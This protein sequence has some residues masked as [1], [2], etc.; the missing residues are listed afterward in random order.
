IL[1]KYAA[2]ATTPLGSSSASALLPEPPPKQ[3]LM[4]RLFNILGHFSMLLFFVSLIVLPM[5]FIQRAKG[6]PGVQFLLL[7]LPDGVME[8][9]CTA[10]IV[11]SAERALFRL[12]NIITSRLLRRGDHGKKAE[13]EGW[14]L[15]V[16]LVQGEGVGEAGGLG[17]KSDPYVVFT[18]NGKTR[19][20][21][22]KL[23]TNRPVWN[24]VLTFDACEDQAEVDP[25]STL[26]VEIFDYDGPFSAPTALGQTEVDLV[27][28]SAQ[29]LS[30]LWV[31]LQLGQQPLPPPKIPPVLSLFPFPP[32][33][34]SLAHPLSPSLRAPTVLGQ[35]EVDLVRCSAQELSN[36]WVPLQGGQQPLVSH[37]NSLPS[38]LPVPLPSFSP[39]P[40]PFPL[41]SPHPPE[42]LSFDAFEDPPS[43]LDV[44]IFDYDGPFSA[45]TALGQAEVDL[46]RS[47]AQELSD[48]W[49]P[50]QGGPRA[51]ARKGG[52][53]PGQGPGQ[54]VE[55]RLQLRVL[56]TST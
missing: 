23:Q 52:K 2:P 39:L 41:P 16:T 14:L 38:P 47:S 35:A 6:L 3:P 26:D 30:D 48:L 18:C 51:E 54:G 8:L 37:A 34:L 40:S 43:T 44:E 7:D 15:T 21:S 36:L 24:E 4:A 17:G 42:V 28:S 27:R 32:H 5:H 55:A 1:S 10:V 29:E 33:P 46:V 13:G 20:S 45:P 11:L 31:P 19:T 56:L 49:V 22:V 50:L 9:L 25:P 12:R 53:A